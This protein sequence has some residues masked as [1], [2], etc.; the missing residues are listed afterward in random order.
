MMHLT[1]WIAYVTYGQ[2]TPDSETG[3]SKTNSV[4]DKKRSDIK[5]AKIAIDPLIIVSND[6]PSPP[7][8]HSGAYATY[9]QI[10]PDSETG[11]SPKNSVKDKKR[12]DIKRAKIA[13]DPLIIV[14]NDIPSPASKAQ[15]EKKLF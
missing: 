2:I 9:G 5:R 10:T 14:S 13:I 4:K 6:I 8:G 1:L 11:P 15:I 3:P 12:S 7:Y